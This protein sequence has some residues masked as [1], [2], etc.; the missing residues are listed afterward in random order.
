M[1]TIV[2]GLP[3]SGTSMMMRML[4]AG[5]VPV[6]TDEKREADEDNLRGYYEDERVK[7][8]REDASWI[9]EAE[10]K[11]VKVISYLLRHLPPGHSYKVIFMERKIPEVLASQ[12]KMMKRRGE[13]VDEVPD[14]VMAGIF[15]NHLVETEE[16]LSQ[17][18]NIETIQVSYND[19]LQNPE[20]TAR[21]VAAFLG[22]GFDVEKMTQVVDP[23]LY[24]QR[25]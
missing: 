25:R 15:E 23:R 19:T 5:G 14:D 17:Q 20:P 7:Q 4:E 16:W 3:R 6:L 13:A 22:G 2:S 21:R 10:E 8:L 9:T 24:R 18:P 11:A 12:R 1:I